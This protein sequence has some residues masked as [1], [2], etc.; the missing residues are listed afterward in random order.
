[1]R[2]YNTKPLEFED[3]RTPEGR[4]YSFKLKQKNKS[5]QT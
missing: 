2:P 3:L 4:P 1:M 5:P